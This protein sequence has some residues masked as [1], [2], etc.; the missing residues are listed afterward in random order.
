MENEQS[1]GSSVTA[2]TTD[3]ADTHRES[4]AQPTPPGEMPDANGPD[5]Q[6]SDV[7][8][9]QGDYLER[10]DWRVDLQDNTYKYERL[11]GPVGSA[12]QAGERDT[13]FRTTATLNLQP[14]RLLMRWLDDPSDNRGGF[15]RG[16]TAS[17]GDTRFL[18][19]ADSPISHTNL[20][21]WA[22]DP[23]QG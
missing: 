23:T 19:Q 14:I 2:S 22:R 8:P 7:S 21:E 10:F 5:A 3:D 6:P 17:R 15:D 12:E 1:S 16:S 11:V 9:P 20:W 13:P 4:G 18:G